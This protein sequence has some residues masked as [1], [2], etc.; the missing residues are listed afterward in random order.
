MIDRPQQTVSKGSNFPSFH[1]GAECDWKP[2]SGSCLCGNWIHHW[3]M[4]S[5]KNW[6]PIPIRLLSSGSQYLYLYLYL[7]VE[8]HSLQSRSQLQLFM[9]SYGVFGGPERTYIW[10]GGGG[11]GKWVAKG[12]QH[13]TFTTLNLRLTESFLYIH[14]YRHL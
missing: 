7:Q 11:G 2:V 8:L 14:P 13:G 1:C 6:I 5:I 4:R 10:S 12:G 3:A 9:W